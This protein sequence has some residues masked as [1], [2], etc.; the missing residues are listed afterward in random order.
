MLFAS[1]LWVVKAALRN[2]EK[3]SYCMP[4]LENRA[5]AYRVMNQLQPWD[6]VHG[7]HTSGVPM[8]FLVPRIPPVSTLPTLLKPLSHASSIISCS[9]KIV[10]SSVGKRSCPGSWVSFKKVISIWMFL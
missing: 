10:G 9:W 2:L 7:H 6:H 1:H 3:E 4:R 5:C 8:Y